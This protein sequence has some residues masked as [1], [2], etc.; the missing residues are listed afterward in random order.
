MDL[1]G[2]YICYKMI[3]GPYNIKLKH[4]VLHHIHSCHHY[5]GLLNSPITGVRNKHKY[6]LQGYT[7]LFNLPLQGYENDVVSRDVNVVCA[8][9]VVLFDRSQKPESLSCETNEGIGF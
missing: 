3:H 9:L 5:S 4:Y 8:V 2:L 1:V 7:R 6:K